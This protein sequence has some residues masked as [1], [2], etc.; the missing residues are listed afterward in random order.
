MRFA[1]EVI[2]DDVEEAARLIRKQPIFRTDPRTG[3]ID[4]DLINT[5]RSYHQRKLAGDL[6]REFL[7][8]LDEDGK[9]FR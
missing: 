1:D 4:L 5:G 3:L 6:R 7:Q 2:V 9:R 8:L